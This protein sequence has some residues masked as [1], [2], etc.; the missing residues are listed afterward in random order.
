[1]VF[2]GC[3][4]CYTAFR[5]FLISVA[6]SAVNLIVNCI[7]FSSNQWAVSDEETNGC[8]N[9]AF[10]GLLQYKTGY[11]GCANGEDYDI[12]DIDECDDV[13]L[14]GDDCDLFEDA[15][16]TAQA[17]IACVVLIFIYKAL[18]LWLS[19][20]NNHNRILWLLTIVCAGSDLVFGSLAFA[21]CGNF[22]AVLDEFPT[23]YGD[24]ELGFGWGLELFSGFLA[25]FCALLSVLIIIKGI[26]E[27]EK[28][29]A[30]NTA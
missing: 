10:I 25:Y 21:A 15:V 20:C 18:L 6:V 16:Y 23:V 5:V 19:H 9:Y 1:M 24:Y 2:C 29:P 26:G 30:D 27:N 22:H 7:A 11:S 17:A 13:D 3:L 12:E 14:D 4:T 8:K 28:A